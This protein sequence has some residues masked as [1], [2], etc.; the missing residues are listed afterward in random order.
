MRALSLCMAAATLLACCAKEPEYTDEQRACIARQE[1][2]DAKLLD[3]C[4]KVCKAC[5]AGNTVTCTTSC[6]LKGAI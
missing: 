3:Q 4:V 6:T 2:Y 1:A 5:L